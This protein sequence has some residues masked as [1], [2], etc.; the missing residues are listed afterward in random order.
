ME[1]YNRPVADR[2]H[3]L[4]PEVRDVL[5]KLHGSA[6]THFRGLE[7]AGV[8][9][10]RGILRSN[11]HALDNTAGVEDLKSADPIDIARLFN[12]DRRYRRNVEAESNITLGIDKYLDPETN[13]EVL[14][15]Y[16]TKTYPK[17][18]RLQKLGSFAT[19]LAQRFMQR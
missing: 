9:P 4:D 7:L 1:Q 3:E 13:E 14:D 16:A 17:F 10:F 12:L 18:P 11:F 15:I 19:R 5:T 2:Y 8:K 6:A